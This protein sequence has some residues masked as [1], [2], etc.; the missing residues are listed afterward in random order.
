MQCLY[1]NQNTFSS[2]PSERILSTCPY[3]TLACDATN[4][5]SMVPDLISFTLFRG[6]IL[7]MSRAPTCHQTAQDFTSPTCESMGRLLLPDEND[8]S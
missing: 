6:S 3:P 5:R 2:Q 1:L 4:T 8:P 7:D